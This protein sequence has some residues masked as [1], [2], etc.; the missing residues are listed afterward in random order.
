MYILKRQESS[1]EKREFVE[2]HAEV[3]VVCPLEIFQISLIIPCIMKSLRGMNGRNGI[4]A[5]QDYNDFLHSTG[6]MSL[7]D[8]YFNDSFMTCMN[9]VWGSNVALGLDSSTDFWN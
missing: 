3:T 4:S 5:S 6:S 2:T 9:N 8:Q 1:S 7:W